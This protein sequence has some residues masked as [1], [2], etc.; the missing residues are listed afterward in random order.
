[1]KIANVEVGACPLC[2]G[3]VKAYPGYPKCG[4]TLS[5]KCRKCGLRSRFE[6][7]DYKDRSEAWFAAKVEEWNTR[8]AGAGVLR[9]VREEVSEMRRKCY[10]RLLLADCENCHDPKED[11]PAAVVDILDTAIA[12]SGGQETRETGGSEAVKGGTAKAV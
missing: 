11:C 9:R 10:T 7:S 6:G 3:E 12:E 4:V 1:M 5:F 8:E 2:G